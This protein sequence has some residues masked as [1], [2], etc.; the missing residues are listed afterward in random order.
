M[1]KNNKKQNNTKRITY[2]INLDREKIKETAKENK[3]NINIVEDCKKFCRNYSNKDFKKYDVF[4][5]KNICDE[6]NGLL[7]TYFITEENKQENA[8]F[9]IQLEYIIMS[10]NYALISK[11]MENTRQKT[12]E[13]NE[14]INKTTRN[15][16]K[17]EEDAKLRTEEIKH[18]KNDIKSIITTIL[19]IV[20]AFSIIPTAITAVTKI[21]T[22]YILPFMSSIIVFGMF[23]VIFIYSIYQDKIKVSTWFI[24]GLSVIICICLWI[25]SI[26]GFIKIDKNINESNVQNNILNTISEEN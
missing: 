10:A 18:M 20:L 3:K 9:I 26:Y 17:L 4:N 21:D 2:I 19:A 16:E 14:K 11:Q 22:N 6:G 5:L 15:A 12:V 13:F 24:L 23:M 25:N 8:S 7:D 1:S